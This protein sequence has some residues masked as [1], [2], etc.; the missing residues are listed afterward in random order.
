M[1]IRMKKN[2]R[3][4]SNPNKSNSDHNEAFLGFHSERW[5]VK[6]KKK[7]IDRSSIVFQIARK[8]NNK[9]GQIDMC[10]YLYIY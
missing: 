1:K 7:G 6:K 5:K 3:E 9:R 4:R 10:I 2:E 8:K